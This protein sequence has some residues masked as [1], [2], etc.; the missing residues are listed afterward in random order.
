M[1][2]IHAILQPKVAQPREPLPRGAVHGAL[3]PE[4]VFFIGDDVSG[5]INFRLG[6]Y[7]VLVAEIADVL[8][9][10]IGDA[11]GHLNQAKAGA[12]LD[13]YNSRRPLTDTERG[14][15]PAF[16]MA[17]AA[18]RCGLHNSGYL[19]PAIALKAYQSIL[20]IGGFALNRPLA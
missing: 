1:G 20:E 3:V 19:L 16:V 11:G 7:D 5:V 2:Q 17:A 13:G 18:R 9:T 8:V 4:N 6:H 10:W 15:L 12:L 14:A